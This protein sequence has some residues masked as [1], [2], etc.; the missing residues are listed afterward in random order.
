MRSDRCPVC[1]G[2]SKCPGDGNYA[3]SPKEVGLPDDWSPPQV[4]GFGNKGPRHLDKEGMDA[5]GIPYELVGSRQSYRIH[6]HGGWTC[7]VSQCTYLAFPVAGKKVLILV[8]W[9]PPRKLFD[10]V[11]VEELDGPIGSSW[12]VHSDCREEY[13]EATIARLKKEASEEGWNIGHHW[14]PTF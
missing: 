2:V 9:D 3:T 5:L 6:Q 13:A 8:Y 1:G 10:A 11:A 14:A 4:R 7:W 12:S